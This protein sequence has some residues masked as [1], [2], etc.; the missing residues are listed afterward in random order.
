[1]DIKELKKLYLDEQHTVKEVA[2]K[3]GSS[4]WKVYDAMRE[5]NIPRRGFSEANY[6]QYG[7]YKPK[8]LLTEKVDA[9]TECLKIA[10]VML[11]WAEGYKGN[12]GIDFANSDPEMI[13][14][15]LTFLRKVCGISE[16]RLRVY[17]YAFE[18]Q[19]LNNL[20]KFWSSVT[21]IPVSQFSKPYV[22]KFKPDVSR[23]RMPRGLI[24]I[25]YYDK[26]LLHIILKWIKEYASSFK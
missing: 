1:M 15:F 3:M 26:K 4:F 6:I 14:L 16:S 2:D 25:R 19:N 21:Q 24:H 23:R 5:N 11:Y 12:S 8:F 17:L 18:D 20:K 9:K 10:G 7:K 22:R 13:K